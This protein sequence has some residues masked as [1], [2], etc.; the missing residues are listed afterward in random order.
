MMVVGAIC[1]TALSVSAALCL[2]RLWRADGLA[3]RA[4]ALDTVTATIIS[5]IAV[6]VAVTGDG[7]YA[8]V[9]LV[10]GLLGFLA[11]VAISRFMS[12]RGP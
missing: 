6:G 1:L 11:T 2:L 9:A 4:V 8:D 7:I 5:G 3:D 10:L 12:R